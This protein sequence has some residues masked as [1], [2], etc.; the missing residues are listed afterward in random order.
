MAD[1][2]RQAI[3]NEL[4]SIITSTT[5]LS[6][7]FLA[8]EI[9]K[10]HILDE[11]RSKIENKM[12]DIIKKYRIEIPNK[13]IDESIKWDNIVKESSKEFSTLPEKQKINS[14]YLQE[15]MHNYA[16]HFSELIK[17]KI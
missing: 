3:E 14:F 13:E 17:Q 8:N 4:N 10:I 2:R 15:L 5:K 16:E 6:F 9:K 12:L 1:E 11:E 7:P